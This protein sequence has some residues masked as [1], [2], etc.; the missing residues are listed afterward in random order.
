[1][2]LVTVL[3]S[4]H[5]GLVPIAY[6]DGWKAW[7]QFCYYASSYTPMQVTCTK[8]DSFAGLPGRYWPS[9]Q[10]QVIWTLDRGMTLGH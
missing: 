7:E 2:F 4:R 6:S 3:Y 10:P 5:A 9:R 1:M 8:M